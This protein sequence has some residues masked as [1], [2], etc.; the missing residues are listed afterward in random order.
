MG[1]SLLLWCTWVSLEPGLAGAG[2][3]PVFKGKTETVAPRTYV[4]GGQ[5]DSRVYWNSP[6]TWVHRYHPGV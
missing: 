1:T 3:E 5:I 2:L 4:H 6:G